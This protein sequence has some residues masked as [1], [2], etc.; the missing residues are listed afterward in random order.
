[1]FML[2]VLMVGLRHEVGG[3]LVDLFRLYL[4]GS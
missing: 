2:L 3:G 1:M 4:Q